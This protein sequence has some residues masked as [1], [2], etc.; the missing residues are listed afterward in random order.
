[1]TEVV[2][3]DPLITTGAGGVEKE[4]RT[5]NW[6]MLNKKNASSTSMVIK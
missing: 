1:M 5:R 3:S 4:G 2:M 6:C